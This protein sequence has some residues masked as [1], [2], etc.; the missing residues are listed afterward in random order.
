ML[1]S[2]FEIVLFSHWSRHLTQNNSKS[3]SKAQDC[4]NTTEKPQS[5]EQRGSCYGAA[6]TPGGFSSISQFLFSKYS[7]MHS[8]AGAVS[9]GKSSPTATILTEGPQSKRALC[10]KQRKG[11]GLNGKKS[12]LCNLDFCSEV[13][14]PCPSPSKQTVILLLLWPGLSNCSYT[15]PKGTVVNLQT[16]LLPYSP[17][18]C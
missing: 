11:E 1:K 7:H 13:D 6:C 10:R 16:Y 3:Y 15:S 2:R 4:A 8:R 18:A 9:D 5:T 12:K 14:S 17:F